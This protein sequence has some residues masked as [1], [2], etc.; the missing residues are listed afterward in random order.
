MYR[1]SRLSLPRGLSRP[2]AGLSAAKKGRK[3]RLRFLALVELCF[4]V[5]VG[6]AGGQTPA[7]LNVLRGL[8]PMAILAATER[9]R[10]ALAAN[11]VATT[12]LS[13]RTAWGQLWMRS[14]RRI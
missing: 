4:A 9:G 12:M 14:I 13:S 5:T 10:A 3:T 6:Q 11:Y 7:D 8:S 2:S 1:Y